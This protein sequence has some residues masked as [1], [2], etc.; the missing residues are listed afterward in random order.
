MPQDIGFLPYLLWDNT[1]PGVW[2]VTPL[3]VADIP[4]TATSII[5]T[6]EMAR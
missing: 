3:L 2:T 6:R 4:D 1:L 5:A